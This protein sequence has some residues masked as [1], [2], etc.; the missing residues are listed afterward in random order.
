MTTGTAIGDI[1]N[2]G[3]IDI[4]EVNELD[5]ISDASNH[6]RL[7]RNNYAGDGNTEINNWIKVRLEGVESNRNGIGSR[8]EVSNLG[9]TQIQDVIC[10]GS[11][12]SQSSLTLSYGMRHSDLVESITV[13]WPSGIVDELYNIDVNQII[14]IH[15]GS[16]QCTAA[17]GDLNCDGGYNV[18]D[19]VTLSNCVLAQNCED[20]PYG[21]AGDLNGDGGY[22]VLDVVTLANCVLADNCGG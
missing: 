1:N 8:I 2:D 13:R 4:Y 21:Y 19:I 10:G 6:S 5:P 16:G 7:Y 12:S 17:I 11:Y 9:V 15:E 22:N 14:T 18:L 3:L 20:L